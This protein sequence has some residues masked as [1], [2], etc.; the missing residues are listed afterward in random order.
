MNP[1]LRS[2]LLVSAALVLSLPA[3]AADAPPKPN[4]VVVLAADLG[5]GDLGCFGQKTLKTPALDAMAADGM[6]F[7]QFYAGAPVPGPSRWVFLTGVNGGRGLVRG[8]ATKPLAV[9]AGQATIATVLKGAGYATAYVGRWDVDVTARPSDLGFDTF[10]PDASPVEGGVAFVREHKASPFLLV[11]SLSTPGTNPPPAAAGDFADEKWPAGEKAFA[12]AVGAADRD[13]GRVLA[14]LKEAGV[15]KNTLVIFTS[16]NGPAGGTAHDIER[17]DSNGKGR[18]G[19]GDVLEGG[20]RVPMITRWPGTIAP[21]GENDRQWYVGDILATAAE[22]AGATPPAGLD[23]DSFVEALHGMPSKD[24][25]KRKSP[26]YWESYEGQTGQAVRFGKWKAIRSP[27]VTGPVELY[28]M[29]N[30][31]VEKRDYSVRRPDLKN[32]ATNLLNKH[33]HPDPNGPATRPATSPAAP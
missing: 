3:V 25:W 1:L 15:E 24:Q 2:L 13:A 21:G 16:T 22:L 11:V 32:H 27:M 26:L 6:R 5:Y 18:G 14:A 12:A 31:V 7:T 10:N 23:S 4:V 29:S 19:R 9:P 33:R 8:G 28:D 20:I 30:D 17:F